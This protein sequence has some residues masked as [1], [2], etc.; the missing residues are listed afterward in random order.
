MIDVE[1]LVHQY[2]KTHPMDQKGHWKTR[3]HGAGRAIADS[4]CISHLRRDVRPPTGQRKRLYLPVDL[5][6]VVETTRTRVSPREAWNSS[7]R[8]QIV[9]LGFCTS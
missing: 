3:A 8:R 6:S 9:Q 5:L 4:N 7:L 1:G 2:G